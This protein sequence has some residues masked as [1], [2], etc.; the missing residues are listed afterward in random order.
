MPETSS[1]ALYDA[2]AVWY[3]GWIESESWVHPTIGRRLPELTGDVTGQTVLDVACGE[4]HWSRMLTRSGATV[5]GIDLS[6][7]LLDIAE[8]RRDDAGDA[9]SYLLDDAQTLSRLEDASFDGALCALALMDIP[10][11][12]AVFRA[13]HRVVRP[14]GWFGI[15]VTHPCFDSP[16]ASWMDTTEGDLQRVAPCYLSEG[17]WVST[18]PHGVRG[19][20]G[21]WHRTISTY[22]NTAIRTGWAIEHMIEPVT[23]TREGQ[24]VAKGAEIPRVLMIRFRRG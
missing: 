13:V 11:L 9:P 2:I 12:K 1:P 19:Q 17:H 6:R 18:Y 24:V 20:V 16:H 23:L 10:D 21:A 3:A 15:A 7:A 14:G 22:V 5:T 4:G 8:T